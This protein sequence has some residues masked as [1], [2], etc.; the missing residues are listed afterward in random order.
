MNTP[1]YDYLTEYAHSGILRL[2]MPGHK[3]KVRDNIL[4][5]LNAM[6]IT[7]ITG[8]G[9]LYEYEGIIAESEKNASQL[10]STA[11]TFY[12]TQGST[13]GIQ[14]MLAIMKYE[15]RQVIAARNA[16]RAFLSACVLLGIDVDWVFPS[17][18]D[19]IISGNLDFEE[20]RRHIQKYKRSCL[21]ITSPDY[22]GAM[23]DIE[24]LSELCHSCG[25]LLIVDNAHGACLPFYKQNR[26]PISLG[27]DICC[28][29][30]H[31]ML[32]AYTGA[33]YLHFRDKNLSMGAKE[34]MTLFASTSPS[35]LIMC[36]L[37]LCNV[38]LAD[39]IRQRL[40]NSV[41]WMDE[42]KSS[43]S[44][45]YCF[46]ASDGEPLHLTLNA[47]K[48]GTDGQRLASQLRK[49]GVEYEYAD[50]THII[51]LFSPCD[52][53]EDFI[54]LEKILKSISLRKSCCCDT[55]IY[56]PVPEKVMTIR[57]AAL[58]EQSEIETDRAL[59]RICAAV[60]V[61]CPP[62]IPVA[63]SGERISEECI[64]VM[65]QYGINK[66]RVVD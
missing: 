40:R 64:A 44:D 43:L 34:R 66:I 25:C 52:E 54:R 45:R 30:A 4:G 19:S 1:I 13:L 12:M 61:P 14:T 32:P 46:E 38:F 10:F 15:G 18:T 37:D 63:V 3:G 56:F 9:N 49:N 8:A 36:S 21:Y 17:Y 65:K 28:D 7:E 11:A 24:G 33:A 48:S 58:S 50:N 23:A 2:H 51:M 35:Y 60:N 16:H 42:L 27:A 31:K 62:A 20:V 5:R 6:D 39:E 29:S 41:Q 55:G 53:H 57:E 26:H 47:K 59:G 22:F